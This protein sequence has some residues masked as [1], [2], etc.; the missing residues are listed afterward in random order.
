MIDNKSY[1]WTANSVN[2]DTAMGMANVN[3]NRFV[4]K[5]AYTFS[6]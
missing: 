3:E 1:Q 5:A 6:F 2:Y 4:G